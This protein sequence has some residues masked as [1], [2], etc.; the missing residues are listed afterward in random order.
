MYPTY[1]SSIRG[2]RDILDRRYYSLFSRRA[3]RRDLY[4]IT[5]EPTRDNIEGLLSKEGTI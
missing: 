5:I 2:L 1:N 3:V 4:S